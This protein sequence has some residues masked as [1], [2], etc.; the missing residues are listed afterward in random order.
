MC[1]C[2]RAFAFDYTLLGFWKRCW[3]IFVFLNYKQDKA[4]SKKKRKEKKLKIFFVHAT[5]I[6]LPCNARRGRLSNNKCNSSLVTIRSES[7][8]EENLK[9]RIKYEKTMMTKDEGYYSFE[10]NRHS[11]KSKSD[12]ATQTCL[13]EGK[14]ATFGNSNRSPPKRAGEEWVN[15]K[16]G[17]SFTREGFG[18]HR[19]AFGFLATR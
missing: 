10:H 4:N 9:R 11:P 8:R 1:V 3:K 12:A 14:F 15:S 19:Y 5:A 18:V 13:R 2:V 6:G 16:G 17:F 7:K